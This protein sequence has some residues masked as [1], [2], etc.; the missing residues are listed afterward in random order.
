M[1]TLVMQQGRLDGF[2]QNGFFFEATG[3]DVDPL[4]I[5][6]I[7]KLEKS[8]YRKFCLKRQKKVTKKIR[9]SKKINQRSLSILLNELDVWVSHDAKAV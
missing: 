6:Y 9:P 4:L 5:K 7:S 8:L 3:G 2:S 1:G